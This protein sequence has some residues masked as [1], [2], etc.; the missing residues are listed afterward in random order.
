MSIGDT[1]RGLVRWRGTGGA[2]TVSPRPSAEREAPQGL[3]SISATWFGGMLPPL[4]HGYVHEPYAGAWQHNRECFGPHGVFSAV[5][6]CI[7]T[8]ASD[9]AKLPPKIRRENP[10][11]SSEAFEHHPAARVLWTPNGYQTRVD[12]WGQ[13]MAS[14]LFTGNAYALLV[15]DSRNV[16]SQMHLL[17]PRQ[18]RPLIA[19]DGSI[20]YETRQERVIEALA[21]KYIP[22]RDML[23]HRLL[24]LAHPLLGVTPLFAG[25]Y[26]AQTGQQIQQNSLAFFSNMSRASGVL[27][28]P[29]KISEAQLLRIKTEWEQNF[30]AGAL[31]RAAVLSGGLKWEPLSI[32]AADAQLIEQLRWSV[33]D[34]ARCFRVPMYM[35]SDA[36]KISYKNSEQLARNYYT[37][38]LQYHLESIEA[39]IAAAFDLTGPVYCEFDLDALL[40]MELDIRMTA[41]KE[42]ITAGILTINEARRREQ[43]PPKEGGDEPLVQMQYIPLSMCGEQ[44]AA[45]ISKAEQLLQP[46]AGDDKDNA[47]TDDKDNADDGDEPE[48]DEEKAARIAR[49]CDVFVDVS[50]AER[51]AA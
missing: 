19:P 18:V 28:T 24:C 32:T 31:G 36:A 15:R 35:I 39:R 40:R 38:T 25:G 23:H 33:E 29:D 8:I 34:V 49:E 13:F 41:Y 10:D 44:L 9:I 45:Q 17:D 43:L 47:G 48:S 20:W 14:A 46:D 21:A 27:T 26:S 30:K 11:G 4:S 50:F 22:A 6:A 51:A 37:Q 3:Q 42:A 12:F 7:A 1:L 2:A 16:V 5:Y